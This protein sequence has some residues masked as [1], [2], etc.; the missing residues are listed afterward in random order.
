MRPARFHPLARFA[1]AALVALAPFAASALAAPVRVR[2]LPPAPAASAAKSALDAHGL[3]GTHVDALADQ[4][5]EW[6]A[7]TPAVAQPTTFRRDVGDVFVME[8]DG[9]LFYTNAGG[10]NLLDISA[11]MRAFYAAHGD[12]YDQ[13]AI[14]L[15]TGMNQWLGS[16]GALA[17]AWPVRNDTRGIGLSLYDWGS[18]FGSPARLQQVLTM[19][20][21]GRYPASQDSGIGGPGDS[22]NTQDVLA[23][24]FA[25]RWLSYVFVDSAGTQSP[26]LLGRDW[27]HWGFFADV[28]SSYMEGCDWTEVAPDS[29]RTTGVSSTFGALDRYL[30]GAITRAEIDSFFVVNDPTAFDPDGIYIPITTPFV[31]LGCRGRATWWRVS[32]IERVHG[33]RV[34]DGAVAP[35]AFRVGF[36]LITPHGVDA[37][38]ADLAKLDAI[39]LR[40]PRTMRDGT[41]QR[42]DVDVTL[43]PAP[44]RVVIEHAPLGDTEVTS[45]ARSVRARV[46]AAGGRPPL[47]VDAGSV[48]LWWRPGTSGPFSPVTMT[49]ASPDSFVASLPAPAGIVQYFLAAALADSPQVTATLPPAGAAGPFAFRAGTDATPPVIVHTPPRILGA[50]Q[51][52]HALLAR[53]SDNL[54][55]DSVWCDLRVGTGA[56]QHVALARAGADSFAATVPGG[57]PSGTVV[58]YRFVARDRAQA[59]NVAVSAPGFDTLRVNRGLSEDLENGADWFH[60]NVLFSWRD[61]WH[62]ESDPTAP[63][64]PAVWACG[65]PGGAYAPH[66]DASLYTPFVY[67]IPSGTMLTFDHRWALEQYDATR[68]WD[69][70][71]LEIQTG[72]TS[73][74]W[75]V[76]NPVPGY[77]HVMIGGG[78]PFA[79]GT[80][81]WSGTS[82]GWVRTTLDLTP[83]AGQAVRFRFRMC[84]DDFLGYDGWRVDR[85][86]VLFPGDVPLGAPLAGGALE[87]GP[88]WPNPARTHL[89]QAITLPARADVEWTLFDVQGR[90]AATL[91]SGP[92]DAGARTLGGTLPPDIPN[93]MYLARIRVGAHTAAQRPVVVLR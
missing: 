80:P 24:E 54:G 61:A 75:T 11:A 50:D 65:E 28:D 55:V 90:R 83:W 71:R 93:G 27:Q 21:L 44:A 52:P 45:A 26:A 42:F 8:D 10:R 30:M 60:Q 36:A 33:P 56:L 73:G 38:P 57:L 86:R 17:A 43:A 41:L 3:C 81:C 87:L 72:S 31:G 46:R 91:W 39:R 19:N 77:G 35:R 15:S 23:H 5:A 6:A 85:V 47:A 48:T 89:S 1:L 2:P 92:L 12:D 70:A 88:A 84:S 40:F 7:R 14:Y 66:L 58:T 53:V 9:T 67:G 29:F 78:M 25:H 13:V 20:G 32:D 62:T 51:L 49:P 16:P 76:V 37:T 34:P 64:G 68:A 4:L 69:G 63:A 59:P 82:P 22:F 79:T 74:P 18:A